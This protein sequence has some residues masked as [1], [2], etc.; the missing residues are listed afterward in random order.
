MVGKDKVFPLNLYI[1]LHLLRLSITEMMT[2]AIDNFVEPAIRRLGTFIEQVKHFEKY[3]N[4]N[5]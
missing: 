2:S 1:W 5:I 4:V 3:A